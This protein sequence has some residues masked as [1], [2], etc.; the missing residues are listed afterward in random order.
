MVNKIRRA[1]LY[2]KNGAKYRGIEFNLTY[3]EWLLFW[4]FDIVNR[5]NHGNK[6]NMCRPDD[7]GPYKLGNIFK[8][9]HRCNCQNAHRGHAPVCSREEVIAL[10]EEGLSGRE[11][12]RKLG[13][14]NTPIKRIIKEFK[15][16]T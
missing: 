9:T 10:Y 16:G 5:G 6:L 12:A 1:F 11:I 15:Y 14:S 7:K 2:Q 4:G 3:Q 13:I 8:Q